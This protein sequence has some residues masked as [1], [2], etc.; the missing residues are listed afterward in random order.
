MYQTASM[1]NE[2]EEMQT[3]FTIL[4]VNGNTKS[5]DAFQSQYNDAFNVQLAKNTEECTSILSITSVDLMV[6]ETKTEDIDGKKLIK[7]ARK[8]N[9]LVKCVVIGC[10]KDKQFNA[11]I[12]EDNI[13]QCLDSSYDT[14]QLDLVINSAHESYALRKE[15]DRKNQNFKQNREKLVKIV[16]TAKDAVITFNDQLKVTLVNEAALEMF[17]FERKDIID[18]Y[19]YNL[20]SENLDPEFS[21][22]L[23]SSSEHRKELNNCLYSNCTSF[24]HHSSGTTFPIQVSLSQMNVD[25]EQFFTVIIRDI[26]E[27]VELE[28]ELRAKTEILT[29][30]QRMSHLGHLK[31]DRSNNEE[32][33]SFEAFRILGVMPGVRLGLSDAIKFIHPDDI[34]KFKSSL[35]RSLKQE[36]AFEI[37]HR[38]VRPDN[39]KVTWLHTRLKPQFDA[40]KNVIRIIGTIL[41]ITDKKRNEEA[42]R[43]SADEFRSIYEASYN[44]IP[45]VDLEGRILRSNRRLQEMLGYSKEELLSLTLS[46][47]IPEQD[48][49]ETMTQIRKMFKE[50][51][52]YYEE[53]K[54]FI[55]KNGEILICKVSITAP[56]AGSE[57][58]RFAVMVIRDITD[59]RK[60]QE[61]LAAL[62]E[63]QNTFIAQSSISESFKN[64]LKVL[65]ELTQSEFGFIGEVDYIGADPNLKIHAYQDF[66]SQETYDYKNSQNLNLLDLRMIFSKVLATKKPVIAN[67]IK[68]NSQTDS[69]IGLSF[70]D[71]DT[72][73]G[74]V[75][76]GKKKNVYKEKDIDSL[77]PFLAT[78][79]TMVKAFRSNMK[80]K[81]AEKQV[82]KL[83]DIVSHSNDAIISTDHIGRVTSWN[84]GAEKLL[85][86]TEREM[87]GSSIQAITPSEFLDQHFGLFYDILEGKS[88]DGYETLTIRKDGQMVDVSI[89]MFPMINEFGKTTGISGIIRDI[90]AQKEANE[91]K[92]AFTK[93]LEYE[94]NERTRELDLARLELAHSLKKEKELNELKSKFVATAS[95]QFRTPLAVIKAN[96]GIL[97]MQK[98]AMS[99]EFRKVYEKSYDRIRTHIDKMV[100]L[101][102]DVLILGKLSSR[103]ISAKFESISVV[104]L[105]EEL[106]FNYNEIQQDGRRIQF[107][108][109]GTPEHIPLDKNLM[110]HAISNLI[111]NAFKYSEGKPSP[112]LTLS[113]LPETVTIS[114]KDYGIG[115]PQ[116]DLEHIFDPFYRASNVDEISGTGLGSAIAKEYVELNN[117]SIN[118]KTKPNEGSEFIIEL[119]K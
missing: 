106:A 92:E 80:K 23:L 88:I 29:E 28:N 87:L 54:R 19:I 9:P 73:V 24:A 75:G 11:F 77:A 42:L 111:S 48:F 5:L 67:N 36:K 37:D 25:N 41:D 12:D 4:F 34:V 33:W 66:N 101:M 46:D 109:E 58:T 32:E 110:G 6:V 14:K 93:K 16:E 116:K 45:I 56:P 91:I 55:K 76:L 40:N 47:L 83:A 59:K 7:I 30:S 62:T 50:N 38:I 26:Q 99:P 85:G 44:G 90:S 52:S 102:D 105:C 79:S 68:R 61:L 74:V 13:Y 96:L 43:R 108:T 114:V 22:E 81:K 1:L 97:G 115:I 17:G 113:F 72:L 65:L 35:K 98:D 94:V 100:G 89:S 10:N 112:R 104:E 39:H 49:Q 27:W 78:C 70:Y 21:K 15:L 84:H 2:L 18:M 103:S 57:E 117:G 86:Y 69:F 95:H 53:E 3:D 8:H 107:I 20:I 31:W 71:N 118:L 82:K 63:I 51:V 119:K 60:S 64:I